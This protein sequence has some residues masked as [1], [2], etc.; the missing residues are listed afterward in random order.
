MPSFFNDNLL[1]IVQDIIVI[2]KEKGKETFLTKEV[3]ETQL[4]RYVV[5]NCEPKASFN[6]NYGKFLKENENILGIH[7]IRKNVPIVDE[8]QNSSTCSEWKIL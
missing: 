8:Y 3:I 7:E 6:A 2:F 1:P 5:D 4:G